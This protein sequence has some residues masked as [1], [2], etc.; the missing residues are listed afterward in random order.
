M[1]V[2]LAPRRSRFMAD[3][4][5]MES[6]SPAWTTLVDLSLLSDWMS[7]QGLGGGVIE[8]ATPL[9]GG[10]QNV[11]LRFERGGRTFVLR[12]PPPHP[13]ADS[14]QTMRREARMLA[15]LAGSDVPHPGLIAVSI[16]ET[17]LGVAFYLMEAIDGFNP[18]TAL[19]PLHCQPAA[20][21]RMGLALVDAIAALGQI[22]YAA[23]GLADFGKPEAYLERQVPRWSAQLDSYRQ[24]AGWPGAECLPGVGAVASWLQRHRPSRFTPGILHGDYHMGNVMYRH[25]AP[26]LAAVIDWELTTIGDPLIDL[27]W[28]L[29]TWPAA[30]MPMADLIAVRPWV[31][32]PT[33]AELIAQ[34]RAKS[35]LNLSEIEWYT[36]LACYKLAIILE[37]THARACAGKA[38]RET[39]D[40]LHRSAVGL[41]DHA[42]GLIR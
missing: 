4:Q 30:G 42:A 17:V 25:D 41:F 20:Q 3:H 7:T 6:G 2:A 24:F 15:A 40:R 38:E 5:T 35:G 37:G 31:G 22:D 33:S 28:L 13:R 32:F 29:A 34:Y 19:P 8:N 26:A 12:R 11:L 10:T 9:A 36:V 1:H 14:N 27:G 21:H 18:T 16:D 23:A 39:G